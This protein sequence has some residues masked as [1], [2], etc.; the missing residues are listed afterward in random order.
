MKKHYLKKGGGTT[1]LGH[2]DTGYSVYKNPDDKLREEIKNFKGDQT[3]VT[4]GWPEKKWNI[5]EW[6]K[7]EVKC[8]SGRNVSYFP[9]KEVKEALAEQGEL[10]RNLKF[11]AYKHFKKAFGV[12]SRIEKWDGGKK[13]TILDLQSH[14]K[15]PGFNYN[16]TSVEHYSF[17]I[18]GELRTKNGMSV[19]FS[20]GCTSMSIYFNED[21]DYMNRD[22]NLNLNEFKCEKISLS[23]LIDELKKKII[24]VGEFGCFRNNY[25]VGNKKFELF[26]NR[27]D[28]ELRNEIKFGLYETVAKAIPKKMEYKTGAQVWEEV[29]KLIPEDFYEIFDLERSVQIVHA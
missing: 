18:E 5:V 4:L 19:K 24:S 7:K 10:T 11:P 25:Y 23:V 1:L 20:K 14:L 29:E 21:G 6:E 26:M 2:K 15:I 28:H 12:V 27:E 17:E 3:K 13:I 22:Y 9:I 8:E 16:P